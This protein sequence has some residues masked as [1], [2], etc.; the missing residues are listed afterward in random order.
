MA[1][2]V[3]S[4][5]AR[6]LADL[7]LDPSRRMDPQAVIGELEV[8][9]NALSVSKELRNVMLSPAV[10]PPRKRAVIERL[11]EVAGTSRLVRNFLYVV[12]GHRRVALLPEIRRAFQSAVD[13]RLGVVEAQIISA[14]DLV[15]DH[16]TAVC[17]Q[18]VRMT[19]KKVRCRFS[20]DENLIGGVMA[21]IG[22][23]IY[24]GSVRGQLDVLRRKLME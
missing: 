15:E 13:Q 14:R 8:F 11:A 20:V 21:R 16:R 22:S 17:D 23:T 10:T 12:I 1:L 6:A 3:A 9:E 2:A 19:H 24:D 5:Y 4:R 7:V 18:L